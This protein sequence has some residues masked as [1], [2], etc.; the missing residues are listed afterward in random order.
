MPCQGGKTNYIQG[1]FNPRDKKSIDNEIAG[2]SMMSSSGI[3]APILTAEQTNNNFFLHRK[4]N[5]YTRLRQTGRLPKPDLGQT[6][7]NRTFALLEIAKRIVRQYCP[8]EF[9]SDYFLD[10]ALELFVV[11]H[12]GNDF[13]Y[14]DDVPQ[15]DFHWIKDILLTCRARDF[16]RAASFTGVG[17]EDSSCANEDFVRHFF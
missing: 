11:L 9:V 5:K 4:L 7:P 14:I 6:A 1:S 10:Q 16:S 17:G 13:R 3:S 15:R 12:K 2:D 8:V